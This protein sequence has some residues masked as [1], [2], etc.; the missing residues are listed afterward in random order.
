MDYTHEII[1]IERGATKGSGSPMWRCVTSDAQTVNVFQHENPERDTFGL[2]LMAG[3]AGFVELELGEV[4]Y[5]RN[6]PIKVA[7]VKEGQWWKLAAVEPRPKDAE[8]DA[9]Q[10]INLELYKN[11]AMRLAKQLLLPLEGIRY[12][13]CE[14]TG[15]ERDDEM[16]AMAIVDVEGSVR[17][18]EM[19]RPPHPEKLLRVGKSGK[20][21]SEVNGITPDTLLKD[22][23]STAMALDAIEVHLNGSVV[24]AYNASFDMKALEAD[25]LMLNRPF[26]VPFAVHD[27]MGIASEYFGQWQPKYQNFRNVTLSEAARMLGINAG[28][29]HTA[30]DDAMTTLFLMMA[31]AEGRQ[32]KDV[33]GVWAS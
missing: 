23:V 2:L 22:S 16:V 6:Y 17:Y 15:V 30:V 18:N 3:Y 21:A 33:F 1:R 26:I 19:I 13:D 8:A 29:S 10:A 12:I 32:P 31:I 25:C 9:D 28:Q 27:A 7:L 4:Q 20:S 11:R 24:V 5:W 14:R